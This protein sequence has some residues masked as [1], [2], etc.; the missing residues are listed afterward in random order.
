MLLADWPE[1]KSFSTNLCENDI[2][3]DWFAIASMIFEVFFWMVRYS[4][5]NADMLYKEVVPAYTLEED[6]QTKSLMVIPIPFQ[7][8]NHINAHWSNSCIIT[9]SKST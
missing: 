8:D 2:G 5:L 9:Y 4:G 6:G 3:L 7:T 1:I